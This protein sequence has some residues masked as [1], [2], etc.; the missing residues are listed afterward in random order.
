MPSRG[1]LSIATLHVLL[2]LVLFPHFPSPPRKFFVLFRT[3]LGGRGGG[4]RLCNML[5]GPTR[6]SRCAFLLPRF[7]VTRA[8]LSVG[9]P[10]TNWRHRGR[11][12]CDP[13]EKGYIDEKSAQFAF[14]RL[15]FLY[16]IKCVLRKIIKK[17]LSIY[18]RISL[19]S[20]FNFTTKD[21]P[22]L[23]FC[24]SFF[25]QNNQQMKPWRAAILSLP[26]HRLR[27]CPQT[28]N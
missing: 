3:L 10:L 11:N 13:M 28:I 25:Q 4:G 16:R 23:Y 24:V 2:L 12:I 21:Y 19:L 15:P 1:V 6:H 26:W 5:N 27:E 18:M 22:V 9:S 20:F 7:Y 14:P 17:N 8:Y